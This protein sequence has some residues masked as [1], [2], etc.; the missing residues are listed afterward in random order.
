MQRNYLGIMALS[1]IAVLSMSLRAEATCDPC[2]HCS[3]DPVFIQ[4]DSRNPEL[5]VVSRNL[6]KIGIDSGSVDSIAV[7]EG[8][9]GAGLRIVIFE[10]DGKRLEAG[11]SDIKALDPAVAAFLH[12][13]PNQATGSQK[14]NPTLVD[15]KA[16]LRGE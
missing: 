12:L 4:K 7:V 3:A 13:T 5:V 8:A 1:V 15:P 2:T 9:S 10:D 11:I 14:G 16:F 6:R